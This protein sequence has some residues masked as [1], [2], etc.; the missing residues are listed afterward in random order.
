MTAR[1]TISMTL[2]G[3]Y[4]NPEGNSWLEPKEDSVEGFKALIGDLDVTKALEPEDLEREFL[5]YC[6]DMSILD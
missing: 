5:E 4:I 2:E 1:F 3:S 6:R